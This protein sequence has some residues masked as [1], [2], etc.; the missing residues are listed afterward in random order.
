MDDSLFPIGG[1]PD[2]EAVPASDV[3]DQFHR[4][5]NPRDLDPL[6]AFMAPPRGVSA[7]HPEGIHQIRSIIDDLLG[8]LTAVFDMI[9]P[10][11]DQTPTQFAFT[12]GEAKGH[13][14]DGLVFV[15]KI[16]GIIDA[17]GKN[18]ARELRGSEEKNRGNQKDED[19][20]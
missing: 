10:D 5:I 2:N 13:L 7:L 12:V 19:S 6:P 9:T 14:G 4:A 11:K 3:E 1:S 18:G 15:H 16:S 8:A 20:F 17:E